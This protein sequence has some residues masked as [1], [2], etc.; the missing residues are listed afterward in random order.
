MELPLPHEMAKSITMMI[1]QI[2]RFMLP[3]GNLEGEFEKNC[4]T[5]DSDF[6]MLFFKFPMEMCILDEVFLEGIIRIW[7]FIWIIQSAL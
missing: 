7:K 1:R 5:M 6:G 2:S 4:L 3:I